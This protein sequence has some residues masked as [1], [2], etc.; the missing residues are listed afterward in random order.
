[1]NNPNNTS[2][3]TV[4]ISLK[5]S[6]LET[7]EAK[8]DHNNYKNLELI[9]VDTKSEINNENDRITVEPEEATEAEKLKHELI[10]DNQSNFVE[11]MQQS[12]LYELTDKVDYIE[13]SQYSIGKLVTI[14]KVMTSGKQ[15]FL[16]LFLLSNYL[17]PLTYSRAAAVGLLYSS[18]LLI[19]SLFLY[20]KTSSETP[21]RRR[22]PIIYLVKYNSMFM[23]YSNFLLFSFDLINIYVF[24]CFL[25][26]HFLNMIF[27]FTLTLTNGIYMEYNVYDIFEAFQIILIVNNISGLYFISWTWALMIFSIVVKA[28][29][30]LSCLI[31]FI[32][33]IYFGIWKI[34]IIPHQVDEVLTLLMCMFTIIT[35]KSISAYCLFYLL[36]CLVIG[37]TIHTFENEINLS[38]INFLGVAL[39]VSISGFIELMVNI[40]F[41]QS[42]KMMICK[43]MMV[44]QK[45][46]GITKNYISRPLDL[47]IILS[48]T[49]FYR[50]IKDDKD[51]NPETLEENL[52]S[53][54]MICC[55]AKSQILIRDCNHGGMCE[56]CAII[57]LNT[58]DDC[59][60]CKR[61]IKKMYVFDVDPITKKYLAR[62]VLTK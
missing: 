29:F 30:Y 25:I 3:K 4:D 2:S 15:L 12:Y 22:T 33:P 18:V 60:I 1:M 39:A 42:F 43:S 16:G 28:I 59:P 54:C 13:D 40:S 44:N 37:Q 38:G 11:N 7:I 6:D 32:G 49:N 52:E 58:N 27:K 61:I 45:P 23:L 53:E 17:S 19:Y 36:R 48:G 56:K 35:G 10:A 8:N 50:S 24:Y 14:M 46:Q 34:G 26:V 57:Y 55:N 62:N 47:E 9:D 51:F 21:M 41:F 20:I 5:K 31:C